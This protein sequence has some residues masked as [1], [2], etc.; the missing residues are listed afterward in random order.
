MTVSRPALVES[1]RDLRLLGSTVYV[2]PPRTIDEKDLRWLLE[3]VEARI[4]ATR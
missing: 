2:A 3:I 1:D 4:V